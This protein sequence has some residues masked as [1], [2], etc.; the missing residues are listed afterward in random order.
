MPILQMI[1][2]LEKLSTSFRDTIQGKM[3]FDSVLNANVMF[4]PAND[5]FTH[6][7]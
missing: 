4:F 1:K 6:V 5:I 3:N 2:S 7:K